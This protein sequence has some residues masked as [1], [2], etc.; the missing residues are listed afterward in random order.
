MQ[1]AASNRHP[2]YVT[3]SR[4]IGQHLAR[5]HDCL[6][7]AGR[8]GFDCTCPAVLPALETQVNRSGDDAAGASKDAPAAG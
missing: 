8:Y 5:V 2:L 7:A 3:D 6:E 4:L 1:G